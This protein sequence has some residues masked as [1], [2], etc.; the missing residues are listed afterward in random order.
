MRWRGGS[1]LR[2]WLF[3]FHYGTIALQAK[4]KVIGVPVFSVSGSAPKIESLSQKYRLGRR[5]E[6]LF[7]TTL[8]WKLASATGS[9]GQNEKCQHSAPHL[10]KA[11]WLGAEGRGRF[12]FFFFFY[13][14]YFLLLFLAAL[15]LRCCARAFIGCGKR[16]YS[17]LQCAGFSLR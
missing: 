10:K 6:P 9:C 15:G 16:G 2:S 13:F 8:A 3:L 14:F 11:V 12:V 1:S 17:S 5:R 7:L 4:T